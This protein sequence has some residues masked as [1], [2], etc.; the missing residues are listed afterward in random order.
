EELLNGQIIT[1]SGSTNRSN[2]VLAIVP[3][4]TRVKN[5][6]TGTITTGSITYGD[7]YLPSQTVSN[8]N[9][10]YAVTTSTFEYIHNPSVVS[11]NYY[12]GRLKSKTDTSQAYGDTKSTK[13]E[14]TYDNNLLKTHINWNRNNTASITNTHTYD[15]F[16]NITKKTTSN[17]IDSQTQTTEAGYDSKGR[18]VERKTDNLGLITQ[19]EYND[20]G[21]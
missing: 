6:L 17:S 13:D 8:I 15:G 21:L 12:I 2:I 19:F 9:N 11:A 4:S 20:W 7:Y 3:T 18:F 1:N 10:G 5:F 14:Y 16:G